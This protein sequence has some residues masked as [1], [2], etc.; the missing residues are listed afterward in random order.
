MYGQPNI[1]STA[2]TATLVI[3][4]VVFGLLTAA[5]LYA[6]LRLAGIRQVSY[7]FGSRFA[8]AYIALVAAINLIPMTI[9]I[10]SDDW[11]AA[12]SGLLVF[13]VCGLALPALLAYVLVRFRQDE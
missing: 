13:A 2:L 3:G 5:G 9:T 1:D 10:Q 7:R 6:G 12:T 11:R 4:A 8:L